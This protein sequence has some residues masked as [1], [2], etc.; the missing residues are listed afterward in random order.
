MTF[1]IAKGQ[2]S[3][4]RLDQYL[5]EQIPFLSRS[6]SPRGS[7]KRERAGRELGSLSDEG[8]LHSLSDS[9]SNFPF[10]TLFSLSALLS[11][12]ALPAFLPCAPSYPLKNR[13]KFCICLHAC[14]CAAEPPASADSCAALHSSAPFR[15]GAPLSPPC[16]HALGRHSQKW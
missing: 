5:A 1:E 16:S 10:D 2:V 4:G 15:A 14:S 12:L 13:T 7:R 9:G 11:L 3:A 8:D 6:A